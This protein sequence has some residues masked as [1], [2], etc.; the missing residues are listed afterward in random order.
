MFLL[1][2]QLND[3]LSGKELVRGHSFYVRTLRELLLVYTLDSFSVLG[4]DVMLSDMY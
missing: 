2:G 1:L 3:R 4:R